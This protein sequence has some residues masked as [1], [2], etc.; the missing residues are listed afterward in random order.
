MV[1][2]VDGSRLGGMC[3]EAWGQL[4]APGRLIVEKCVEAV[5]LIAGGVV[6]LRLEVVCHT[7]VVVERIALLVVVGVVCGKLVVPL[8]L[9]LLRELLHHAGSPSAEQ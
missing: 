5:A 7:I 6:V 4:D 8:E 9:E 1:G 2:A 3:A